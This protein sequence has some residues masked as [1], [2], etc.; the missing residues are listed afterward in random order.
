MNAYDAKT[1]TV[2]VGAGDA[3]EPYI[4][5]ALFIECGFGNDSHG[6]NSTKAAV[7][8]CR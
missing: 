5:N 2:D 3:A 6:Q 7:R 1:Y 8:A 4:T